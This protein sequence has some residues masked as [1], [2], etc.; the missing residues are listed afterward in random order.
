MPCDAG[1]QAHEG[2]D[3]AVLDRID[4]RV[5]TTIVLYLSVL[6]PALHF[7]DVGIVLSWTGT[8][9]A[10]SCKSSYRNQ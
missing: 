7:E 3:H 1:R 8:V 2:D 5:V 6:I 4:R 9:A 10:T